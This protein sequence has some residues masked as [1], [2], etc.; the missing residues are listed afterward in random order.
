[1]ADARSV[2][3]AMTDSGGMAAMTSLYVAALDAETGATRWVRFL[4]EATGAFDVMM[5][6]QF[7]DDVG[8]RLLS[9]DSGTLYYQT[10]LGS[11]AALDADTGAIRWLATYPHAGAG[12]SGE[13]R[14][15]NPA[16]VH[17]G[18]VLVAPDDAPDLFAFDAATGRLVWHTSLRDGEINHLL[19]VAHG[20]LIATG[21]R[22][23]S[24]DVKTGQLVRYWPEGGTGF[25]GFG[26]GLLAGKYIYWPTRGE[27]LVLDQATGL[28]ADDREPIPLHQAFG[29]TGG[30]LAAGDGYVVVAGEDALVVF[31]QN[32]RLIHRYREAIAAAP[33][34]AANYVRLAR[35]AEATGQDDLALA[36]LNDGLRHVRPA[37]TLD[38][39]PLA[40][41]VRAQ[42]YRLLMRLA[43]QATG[44]TT[45]RPP[46]RVSRPRPRPR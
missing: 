25:Q 38:G 28:K 9:L 36:T 21:N 32:S 29:A 22:V 3:V 27:I 26:R 35:V 4:G 16:I 46:A 12:H 11:V 43:A 24:F 39:Q 44:R 15:L 5:G 6:M 8:N 41:T 33:G 42:Q 18:L 34:E 7:T 17:D 1:M 13:N 20:R 14:D 2:Y 37:E 45:G 40:E 10:N 31:C 30:N 23:W 19:G